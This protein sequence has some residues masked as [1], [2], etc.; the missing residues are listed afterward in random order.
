MA[1]LLM[2][3]DALHVFVFPEVTDEALAAWL[4]ENDVSSMIGA[5]SERILTTLPVT[6]AA[7]ALAVAT[8]T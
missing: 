5:M 4:L 1:V 6:A 8:D 2:L 3:A 7:L